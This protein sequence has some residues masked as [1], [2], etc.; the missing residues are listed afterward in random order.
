MAKQQHQHSA[1]IKVKQ[2]CP[3]RD[4]KTLQSNGRIKEE[5]LQKP[6][7]WQK[8]FNTI[9]ICREVREMTLTFF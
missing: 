8:C 3:V 9:Y 1:I 5:L 2:E 6:L 7:F 4:A